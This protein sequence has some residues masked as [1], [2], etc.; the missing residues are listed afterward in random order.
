MQY[1]RIKPMNHTNFNKS[2]I[3]S[4]IFKPVMAWVLNILIIV[5]GLVS[6]N[7]LSTRMFPVIESPILSIETSYSDAGPDVIESQITKPM[8]EQLM[9]L[10]GLKNIYS[11]SNSSTSNITLEFYPWANMIEAYNQVQTRVATARAGMDVGHI[12]LRETRIRKND[13]NAS[14]VLTMMLT[15]KGF[16][17]V[18]LGDAAIKYIKPEVEALPGTAN[19][20]I[21]G[22]GAS[23]GS[24]A[25]KMEIVVDPD[26]LTSFNLT[27]REVLDS[28]KNQL[29]RVPFGMIN[30]GRFLTNVSIKS[31]ANTINAFKND[32]FIQKYSQNAN[33][34]PQFIPLG[35]VVSQIDVRSE[36]PTF[37]VRYTKLDKKG[38]KNS[39]TFTSSSAVG[40]GLVA[41][42]RQSPISISNAL[43][44]RLPII[45]QALPKGMDL[46]IIDNTADVIGS[47]V[48]SVYRALAEAIFFVFVVIVLFLQSA[49]ASIIPMVTIPICLTSG[50]AVMYFCG[51]TIN[52]LTLLAMV[53]A[54][55]LVVDDAVVVLENIYKYLEKG[56]TRLQAALK[57]TKEIQFSIIAMTLTL[58][59]VYAPISLVPGLVGNVFSE[60]AFTLT[61]MVLVSGFTALV[62]S[63]MMCSRLL[64]ENSIHK[65][66]VWKTISDKIDKTEKYYSVAV[67][68]SVK[69]KKMIFG[70]TFL[71]IV[72][73]F[74]VGK[75]YLPSTLS[76]EIDSGRFDVTFTP[77]TGIKMNEL[78][79]HITQLERNVE[80]IPQVESYSTYVDQSASGYSRISAKLKQGHTCKSVLANHEKSFGINAPVALTNLRMICRNIKVSGAE[81]S[82]SFSVAL[83]SNKDYNSLTKLGQ[84]LA[85]LLSKQRG[86]MDRGVFFDRTTKVKT[87]TLIPNRRKAAQLGVSLDVL[88]GLGS[89]ARGLV[90]GY[91]SKEFTRSEVYL[92]ASD[93]I[94]LEEMLRFGVRNKNHE[95]I[96]LGELVSVLQT[97]QRP[98]VPR[99]S[100]MRSFTIFAEIDPK[101]GLGYVYKNF[102]QNVDKLLPDGYV[103]RPTGGL[104]DYLEESNNTYY[105]IL[106]SLVFI[107]LILAAQFESFSDPLIVMGTVPLSWVGAVLL[108]ALT[109]DGSLNIFSGIGLLT[110]VGLIT[111]HG[112]LIV[113]FANQNMSTGMTAEDAVIA[114]CITR[115]RPIIM[116]TFAMILGAVPLVLSGGIGYEIRRQIGIVIVG[117]MSFGTIF[118]LLVVPCVYVWFKK[119][120]G[121]ELIT[122]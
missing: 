66:G 105:I 111:K 83:Q 95:I 21:W 42:P 76:P 1:D 101:F 9:G 87:Y 22:G 17:P 25:Y 52:L 73:A 48:Q 84:N 81:T 75:Y 28:M 99:Q 6:F 15:G 86:V 88:N 2:F 54:T 56:E 41:Q 109:P 93:D 67:R 72:G 85:Q 5:V 36:D 24:S 94:S 104:S 120:R 90:A 108:L 65:E 51:Y 34:N 62:L 20:N 118:T 35:S 40:I 27:V 59:A 92:K 117:G 69:R 18:Q 82:Q 55:G 96:P 23:S 46:S 115:F 13:S 74:L 29:Y 61:G 39:T 43:Q 47:S 64:S 107:Y 89:I 80:K 31:E 38:D 121:R 113:D 7:Q 71:I 112:I 77:P 63:P 91:F 79:K 68:E 45:K 57:G 37:K 32:V 53:L 10:T 70:S 58:A 30:D 14:P 97:S 33:A 103:M 110:L 16:S 78:N 98:S 106:L 4:F 122:N 60:F 116:T 50:F 119:G 11:T 114:A 3:L 8:E 49:K 100:G 44:N 102:R 19:L 12:T 26:T